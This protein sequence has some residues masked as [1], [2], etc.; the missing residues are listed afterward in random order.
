MRVDALRAL[1]A[2]LNDNP[3]LEER[4]EIES[5]LPG[6]TRDSKWEVRRELALLLGRP[7]FDDVFATPLLERLEVDQT[8]WVRETA[9]RARKQRSAQ[10]RR[11]LS[12]EL[13]PTP[14][15]PHLAYTAERVAELGT[16][17]LT[18]HVVFDLVAQG[19]EYFYRA[20]AA[21][22]AHEV[23]TLL[24]PI[25][26]YF[27]KLEHHLDDRGA[28]DEK[29]TT[30]TR[31]ISKRLDQLRVLVD[32]ITM[33]ASQEHLEY[34]PCE[35]GELVRDAVQVAREKRPSEVAIVYK[36]AARLSAEVNA[37]RLRQALVNVV[38]NALEAM[39]QTGTLTITGSNS[40]GVVRLAFSDTG[41]GLTTAQLQSVFLRF[42]TTKRA[43]GGTG[44]GLPIAKRIV[45][46]EHGGRIL[47]TSE[48][49]KG[50]NVELTLPTERRTPDV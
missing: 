39:G 47:M 25:V 46:D 34:R 1:G 50:T 13:T 16:R 44:L 20:L 48:V 17:S 45:Q 49:G 31:T 7:S 12:R 29:A 18:P 9:A 8:R 42:R 38:S 3:N 28:L 26:G 2:S 32:Q 19:G 35:L 23:R 22:T 14:V 21:D 10:G 11:S 33:Y 43:Q 40:A 41:P 15:E 36:L 4:R 37:H 5:L 24:T 30:Y 27:E 6:M